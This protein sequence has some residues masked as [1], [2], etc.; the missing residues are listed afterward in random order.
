M[1]KWRLPKDLNKILQEE[2]CW[3]DERFD[4]ILLTVMSG[5]SYRGRKIALV[6]SIEFD[7]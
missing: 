2:D 3:D 7:P 6:W 5:T 1:P 4:P